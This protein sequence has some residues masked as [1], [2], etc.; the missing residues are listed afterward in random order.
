MTNTNNVDKIELE[1]FRKLSITM[2]ANSLVKR[3][4]RIAALAYKAAYGTIMSA[5]EYEELLEVVDGL[6]EPIQALI[7]QA[8]IDEL[9]K[10]KAQCT[11]YFTESDGTFEYIEDDD[12]EE[13]IAQLSEETT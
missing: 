10:L 1:T 9:R 2:M 5:K 13:R 7:T 12:I 3:T 6:V 4:D 11:T 8:K